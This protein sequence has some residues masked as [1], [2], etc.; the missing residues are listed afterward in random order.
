MKGKIICLTGGTG[1][2]G[3]HLI[4]AI[5]PLKPHSIRAFSRDGGKVEALQQE[6]PEAKYTLS[7][8]QAD[9]LDTERLRILFDGVDYIIH[10]AAE[11]RLNICEENPTEAI[12][13]NVIGTQNVFNVAHQCR[14]KKVL[15]ISTDKSCNPVTMYGCTKLQGE[16]LAQRFNKISATTNYASVRYGNVWNSSDSVIKKWDKLYP[17][18]PLLVT[19]PEMTR[20]YMN[21]NSAVSLVLGALEKMNDETRI[22]IKKDMKSLRI[23]DILDSRYP[24]A[25]VE[26]TG[27]RGIEKLHEEL[28]PGYYSNDRVVPYSELIKELE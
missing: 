19:D 17:Q 3:R 18:R 15:H 1:F 10:C 23:A 8:I 7:C 12:R 24:N 11:K 26:I 27:M 4:K 2:L 9:I 5:L 25:K 16:M 28:Y 6:F 22:F 20:F 21:I 14:V 13:I